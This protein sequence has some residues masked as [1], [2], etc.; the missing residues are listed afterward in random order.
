MCNNAKRFL[1]GLL[2]LVVSFPQAYGQDAPSVPGLA[3][4]APDDIPCQILKMP[5]KPGG[6]GGGGVVDTRRP[7]RLDAT[8]DLGVDRLPSEQMRLPDL[9][10]LHLQ[11]F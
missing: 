6:G 1:I 10:Q 7:E 9:K 2:L 4:C 11:Q 3:D 8:K 5:Q